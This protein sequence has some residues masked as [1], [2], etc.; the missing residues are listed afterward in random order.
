MS[1]FVVWLNCVPSASLMK[2]NEPTC[3]HAS[4][5]HIY[6]ILRFIIA[7]LEKQKSARGLTYFASTD[8]AQQKMLLSYY[9][10]FFVFN[11]TGNTRYGFSCMTGSLNIF[12][13]LFVH[14]LNYFS[15]FVLLVLISQS[16][17][18]RK[19]WFNGLFILH[20]PHEFKW[21][22]CV[23]CHQSQK[24]VPFGF[25]FIVWAPGFNPHKI[26]S[27]QIK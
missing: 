9:L 23:S 15:N 17:L 13:A 8:M 18:I 1:Q 6:I 4:W 2:W 5:T 16:K 26:T 22:C 21:I 20:H 11:G 7:L 12:P 24:T 27:E 3:R 10:Y 14:L 19:I 25:G